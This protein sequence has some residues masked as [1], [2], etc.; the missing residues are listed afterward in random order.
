MEHL[1]DWLM[2]KSAASDKL[3]V[4]GYTFRSE[5]WCAL[6]AAAFACRGAKL[7]L[8]LTLTLDS[9]G[10]LQVDFE[11]VRSH[12]GNSGNEE[13]DALADQGATAHLPLE[14][15]VAV[16]ADLDTPFT[17]W[18]HRYESPN[19]AECLKAGVEVSDMQAH[20][21]ACPASRAL[22][23]AALD[24]VAPRISSALAAVA[25]NKIGSG[26]RASVAGSLAE[27]LLNPNRIERTAAA[28]VDAPLVV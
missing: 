5:L 23:P 21:F 3:G 20:A 15:A 17:F 13:A 9:K 27:R 4:I 11:W 14:V 7:T 16:R 10:V 19:C 22:V 18:L 25:K 28:I 8:T 2:D 12:A 24:N 26:L 1:F 6:A